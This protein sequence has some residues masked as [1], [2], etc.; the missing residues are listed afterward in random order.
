MAP[1]VEIVGVSKR[2]RLF[3]EKF[4][5]LKE[6]LIHF[7]KIP[8]EDF[9]A[10]RDIDI[11]VQ[12]GETVGLLG[13]NGSGKSTLLKCVAGILQPTL[14]EIRIRGRMAALLEL[15]AGFH[16]D[17]S[18]RENVFLNASLLGVS[19]REVQ[20]KFDD[21]VAFAEL[22]PHIDQQVKYYS[23]G[24]YV[25]LGFAVA[26]NMEP[27][28]LL[29]DEVLAVGDELFQ[30]KCIDRIRLFQREGRTIVFVTHSVDQVRQICDR[31]VVL[32]RGEMVACDAPGP[33]IR[34]Y[35]EHLLQRQEYA[36]AQRLGLTEAVE[37]DE[38]ADQGAP[39]P[40]ERVNVFSQEAKR[41]LQVRIM[42]V[43]FDYPECGERPYVVSGEPLAINIAYQASRPITDLVVGVAVY[44]MEGRL[45][46]GWNTET[47]GVSL[48][49][50]NGAG[51]I[52]FNIASLPLLDGT[53]PVTIGIHSRDEGT[54]Y[55]WREQRDSFEVMSR[56]RSAGV[57]EL[58]VEVKVRREEPGA[59]EPGAEGVA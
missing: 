29:I 45:L 22:E 44:D 7:G 5:S 2:F 46:F 36:E 57:L 12:P 28:V 37:G 9:W 10:L 47:M 41:N 4:T 17:L 21:I 27:D 52:S 6:R 3:N 14:G 38:A 24:M 51:E 42:S 13:H 48:G 53:Y 30:R 23:S 20:R 56:S 1:A 58:Q 40:D 54:V 31:A 16:P 32:D 59:E 55:D 50:V 8:Y 26:V 19:R 34:T 33:A 49:V 15:G 43:K 35:R 39:Q 25:R 11:V 18:G